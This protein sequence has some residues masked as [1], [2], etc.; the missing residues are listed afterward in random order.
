M[1]TRSP[2]RGRLGGALLLAGWLLLLATGALLAARAPPWL[3]DPER[4]RAFFLGFGLL[5]PVAFVMVQAAQVV[6]APLPGQVLGFVAGYL[7]GA[8]A[9]TVLSVG[10]ATIGTYVV[11]RLARRYGRPAVERL[12]HPA[13]ID[14][15][16]AAVEQRGRLALLVVFLIPG[17]PDDAI[18]FA[19]GLTRLELRWILLVSV[20]GRLPGYAVV[21]LAGSRLAGGRPDETLLLLGL[22][23]AL[24]LGAYLGRRTILRWLTRGAASAT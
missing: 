3:A 10:G 19:A 18:C 16:D 7:F 15:F 6:L 17:L 8:V 13:T 24:S 11:V 20:V 1:R 21:S 9:G 5:A 4:L 22:L 23:A 12:V 14:Q 2:Y